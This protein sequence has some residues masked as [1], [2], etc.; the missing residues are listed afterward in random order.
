MPQGGPD[1][2][3]IPLFQSGND[4]LGGSN[5]KASPESFSSVSNHRH[6]PIQSPQQ[7]NQKTAS[8]GQQAQPEKTA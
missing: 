6:S 3:E 2:N 4:L 8:F 1:A 7:D 5:K